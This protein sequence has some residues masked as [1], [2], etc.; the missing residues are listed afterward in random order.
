MFLQ[1]K[2]ELKD[3]ERF[4]WLKSRELAIDKQ[5]SLLNLLY[6]KKPSPQDQD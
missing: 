3:T 6:E 2:K 5:K 1:A 4:D